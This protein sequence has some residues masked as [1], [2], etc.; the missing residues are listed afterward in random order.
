LLEPN[1]PFLSLLGREME[2]RFVLF[3][4]DGTLLDASTRHRKLARARLETI[5]GLAGDEA[6]NE[7]ARFSGV[8]PGAFDVDP[9]GPL[10]RAPR[11]EDLIVA[12]VAIYVS[13]QPWPA[14][15]ELAERAYEEADRLQETLCRPSLMEGVEEA[16]RNMKKAGFKLG[17]ATNGESTS[18]SAMMEELGM[19][20]LFDVVLGADSVGEAKPAPEMVLLACKRVG[21]PPC[22]ALFVG[23][24]QEDMRAGRAAS[25]KAVV[26]VNNSDEAVTGLADFSLGSVADIR[27]ARR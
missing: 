18:A 6:A 15:R 9:Q 11:R 23:D 12:S 25:V 2:A 17:I 21:V 20:D 8:V 24:Q 4:L 16:L 7:W 5:K 10:A 19:L 27:V 14:A 1:M 13:G 22:R 3:D 26:A